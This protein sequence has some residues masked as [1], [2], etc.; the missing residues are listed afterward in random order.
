MRV[1]RHPL[2]GVDSVHLHMCSLARVDNVVH[3]LSLATSTGRQLGDDKYRQVTSKS[4]GQ[5]SARVPAL[6]MSGP[7]PAHL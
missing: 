2:R 5:M 7:E 1:R 6:N 3:G 4:K